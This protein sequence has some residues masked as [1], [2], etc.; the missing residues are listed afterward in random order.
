MSSWRDLKKIKGILIMF[1]KVKPFIPELK[2]KDY[3]L[4]NQYYCGL[5]KSIKNNFGN[6]PRL[7]LSFDIT[8][9]AIL[10]DSLNDERNLSK[11]Y[12][13]IK[14]PIKG[15]S[16]KL[17]NDILD[18][19]SFLNVY[20]SYFKIED[21]IYDESKVSSKIYKS[22]FKKYIKANTWNIDLNYMDLELNTLK[23]YEKKAKDLNLDIISNPFSSLVAYMA[24]LYF[25][26]YAFE[27]SLYSL[28]YSLGKWIYITDAYE[29]LY[30]D[31][32]NNRFNPICAIFNKFCLPY[33]DFKI[34]IN[35]RIEFTLFN[36]AEDCKDKLSTLPIKKNTEILLNIL[37]FG[38]RDKMSAIF[39]E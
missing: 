22:I 35:E 13:C 15:T 8:F 14:H 5:C 36:L 9:L 4:F 26:G 7:S 38:L 16:C 28:G 21:D 27:N 29:D 24:S 34:H 17:N 3:I 37:S 12:Y 18:Y 1:G 19:C 10:L 30:E 2:M 20:L 31:M 6:I 25:K 33:E 32:K 11:K 39:K 23:E